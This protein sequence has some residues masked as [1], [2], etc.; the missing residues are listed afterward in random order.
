MKDPVTIMLRLMGK[1]M[2]ERERGILSELTG[3]RIRCADYGSAELSAVAHG[4][5]Q[6]R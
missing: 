5:V 6:L 1:Y 3:E 2:S 4:D